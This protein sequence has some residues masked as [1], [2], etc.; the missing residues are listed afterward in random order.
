MTLHKITALPGGR[1]RPAMTGD[2]HYREAEEA[3]HASTLRYQ[4][5]GEMDSSDPEAPR[6]Y[7]AAM[8]EMLRAHT[9]A[10]LAAAGNL[11]LIA[12][13]DGGFGP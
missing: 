10:T 5:W 8:W 9:H 13:T 6:R 3:I 2:E 1:G 12:D 4:E 11:A 7:D